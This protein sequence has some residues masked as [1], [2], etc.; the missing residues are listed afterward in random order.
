MALTFRIV[1]P[2]CGQ[3]TRAPAE[4]FYRWWPDDDIEESIR[5]ENEVEAAIASYC[6]ECDG[7][8]SLVVKGRDDILRPILSDEVDESDWGYYQSDLQLSDYFPKPA[9]IGLGR[10]VPAA[11]RRVL[12]DLV[13]DVNRKRN[14]VGSLTLCRSIL[15]VA[16]RDL[17][18]A[19]GLG[20]DGRSNM[21]VRVDRL[22]DAGVITTAL[23]E[24]AHEIRLDGNQSVHELT[25]EM[26]LAR[27][28]K[29]FLLQFL[30]VAFE[31][32]RRIQALK[33][34]KAARLARK[35]AG[36]REA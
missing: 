34:G 16:L 11:I 29:D 8:V 6:P 12:P 36:R 7:L 19:H 10:T 22:K 20:S 32:P 33:A 3:P 25:G 35:P 17:E 5:G 30:D 2:H 26:S 18:K 27:A 4:T 28:Y 9:V 21:V 13:E 23:A 14:A 24:W 15:E 31:L 1:C